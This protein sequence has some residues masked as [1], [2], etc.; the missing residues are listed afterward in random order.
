MKAVTADTACGTA[1]LAGGVLLWWSGAL[2]ASNASSRSA[3][4]IEEIL[5]IGCSA[6]GIGAVIWWVFAAAAA[7]MAQLLATTGH[8]H[9]AS[10]AAR[11]S[12]A[13]MR[14]LAAAAL[15]MNLLA[16]PAMA[17]AAPAFPSSSTSQEAETA[18][19]GGST[20]WSLT[21]DE[22][23][24]AIPGE[25]PGQVDAAP[26]WKPLPSPST[27]GLVLRTDTARTPD[28]VAT[29]AVEVI[30]KPGDSLWTIAAAHLG[31]FATDLEVAAAWPTWYRENREGIGED[32]SLL[33]PGQILRIPPAP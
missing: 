14:R 18:E 25:M 13:C 22:A 27:G 10:I 17:S 8:R 11:F 4:G 31:A 1:A 21:A 15:G 28:T 5:G 6:A 23:A 33:F 3:A 7:V 2:I 20:S 16:V 26:S 9:A 30:V 24:D 19:P 32:P 12:P 29:G